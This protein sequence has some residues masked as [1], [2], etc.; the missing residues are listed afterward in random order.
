MNIFFAAT[1]QSSGETTAL[2]NSTAIPHTCATSDTLRTVFLIVFG[3][4][5][6][7]A[8]FFAVLAGARYALSKGEPDNIQ[9]AKNELKYAVIGL[10]IISLSAAIVN[11]VLDK[12]K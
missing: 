7:M 4:F 2:V 8:F 9:K 6:A 5:G 1:C 11:F 10:I 3:I 12:L